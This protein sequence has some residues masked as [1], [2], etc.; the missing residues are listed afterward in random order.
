[1]SSCVSSFLSQWL[2]ASVPSRPTLGHIS[3]VAIA[4]SRRSMHLEPDIVETILDGIQSHTLGARILRKPF[5]V[6]WDRQRVQI[7]QDAPSA[8]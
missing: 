7:Q 3:A 8:S 1:L 5:P 2:Q 6:E 4:L